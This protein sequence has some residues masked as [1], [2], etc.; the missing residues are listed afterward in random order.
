[1]A[2]KKTK[3]T[4]EETIEMPDLGS[5]I[6]DSLNKQFKSLGYD[7]SYRLPSDYIENGTVPYYI[8]T[9][10]YAL[11][12]AVSNKRYGGLP[13]GRIIE[14]TGLE[15]SGKT[16]LSA[17]ILAETQ[18]MGGFA[19]YIDT[20]HS[21]VPEYFGQVCG[22]DFTKNWNH[23]EIEDLQTIF[24]IIESAIMKIR[25][26]DA[27][28]PMTIVLDSIMG[29]STADELS[30]GYGKDG[31]ATSKSIILSKAMRKL[32]NV[33]GR[34]NI[35]FIAT[36]QLRYNVNANMP[37]QDKYITSGGKAIDF[38]S[39]VKIRIK[40][41]KTI[42]ITD[43]YGNKEKVG[44]TIE[45]SII[46]NRL[47]PP[48]KVVK[49]DIMYQ[50]GIDEIQSIIDLGLRYKV[51]SQSGAYY[52]YKSSNG[53]NIRFQKSKFNE[54]FTGSNGLLDELKDSIADRYIMVYSDKK[55]MDTYNDPNIKVEDYDEESQE[56]VTSID[57]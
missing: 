9:G 19:M 15:Q 4:I 51:L 13:A 16:L 35:T 33:F 21:F 43:Q 24:E 52:D 11:D 40:R 37:G 22:I 39:S 44:K 45:A 23:I 42:T 56:E 49:F 29:S 34:Q 55:I 1:M 38:H 41:I 54:V 6:S 17:H 31:Y 14:I 27:D 26:I 48:E 36:N 10:N 57:D 3:N 30:A 32:T 50:S 25:A 46:K 7:V 20:E 18:K 12:L 8:P 5:I 28:I 47:G 2:K 53:E